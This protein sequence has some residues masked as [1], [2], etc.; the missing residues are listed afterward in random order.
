MREFIVMSSII[1]KAYSERQILIVVPK[2]NVQSIINWSEFCN[3]FG[4]DIR[5]MERLFRDRWRIAG[6]DIKKAAIEGA[7]AGATHEISR[8]SAWP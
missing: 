4:I 2:D 8:P 7:K 5:R 6:I 3:A 1:Q